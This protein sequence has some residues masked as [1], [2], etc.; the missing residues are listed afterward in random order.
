MVTQRRW[1]AKEWVRRCGRMKL[2]ED[3]AV[4]EV[5]PAPGLR[6]P[7][8]FPHEVAC[9][10]SPLPQPPQ[11][12]TFCRL[13]AGT[14]VRPFNCVWYI[15][16]YERNASIQCGSDCRMGL[17]GTQKPAGRASFVSTS[18]VVWGEAWRLM[19]SPPRVPNVPWVKQCSMQW[20]HS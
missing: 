13:T 17:H 19:K 1:L 2:R 18:D 8:Q 12:P 20:R 14:V 7:P 11:L 10:R 4:S 5:M 15:N 3:A 6:S 9:K 16:K